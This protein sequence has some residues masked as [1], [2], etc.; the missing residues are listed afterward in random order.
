MSGR[1]EGM[2]V[3]VTGAASG[4]GKATAERFI[5]DGANVV[6]ADINEAAGAAL[7]AGLGSRARFVRVDHNDRAQIRAAVAVAV[8]AFGALDT[9]VA[10]AG[11]SFAGAVDSADDAVL[12]RVIGNNLTAQFKVA[13]ETLPALRERVK[14]RHLLV[15]LLFTGSLQS[16]KAKPNFSVYTASKHGVMGMVRG[17]ALELAPVGIRVNGVCPTVT[18]TPLLREF[19]AAMADDEEEAM[20]RFRATVPLGVMAEPRDVA[21]AFAFLASPDARMITGHAL[22]VDGGQMAM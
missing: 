17:L 2:T 6:L 19:S 8:D 4:I 14:S 21:A 7:A 12:D 11:V 15:S 13:Q 10:N 3:L 22:T 18:D 9:V 20:R 5:A 1:L 16:L